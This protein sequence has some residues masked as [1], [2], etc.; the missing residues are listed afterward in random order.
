M[1][2]DASVAVKWF[3]PEE[4]SE[5]ARKLLL[6]KGLAAPELIWAE[7]GN[8]LLRKL[9]HRHLTIV[10]LSEAV[11][12]FGSIRIQPHPLK[13]LLPRAAALAYYAHISI[14]DAFYL[15]L[16]EDLRCALVTADRELFEASKKPDI[17]C[18]WIEDVA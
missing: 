18:V 10:Q 17:R 2:I 1:V 14:Y 7:F 6:L 13:P 5:K 12:N 11:E 3:V 4:H 16:A 15:A 9:A 8:A